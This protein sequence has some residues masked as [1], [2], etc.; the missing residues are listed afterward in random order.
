MQSIVNLMFGDSAQVVHVNQVN[1]G[2][3]ETFLGLTTDEDE[4]KFVVPKTIWTAEKIQ[5]ARKNLRGVPGWVSDE[6][7]IKQQESRFRHSEKDNFGVT[8]YFRGNKKNICMLQK[9]SDAYV[10]A[11]KEEI[12]VLKQEQ[13]KSKTTVET[14]MFN[15]RIDN[16]QENIDWEISYLANLHKTY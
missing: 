1:D 14:E 9:Y 11:C 2:H 4:K 3:Q 10:A 7:A 12:R 16:M 5:Q 13:A 8:H 15:E 6:L